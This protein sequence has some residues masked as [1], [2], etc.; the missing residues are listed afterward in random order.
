MIFGQQYTNYIKYYHYTVIVSTT[1]LLFYLYTSADFQHL[2]KIDRSNLFLRDFLPIIHDENVVKMSTQIFYVLMIQTF[3]LYTNPGFKTQHWN[4]YFKNIAQMLFLYVFK[5]S[6][7][8]MKLV[9]LH[10]MFDVSDYLFY[11][12]HYIPDPLT[13]LMYS[14]HLY[15]KEFLMAFYVFISFKEFTLL[16][17]IV[18][19]EFKHENDKIEYYVYFFTICTIMAYYVI[20]VFPTFYKVIFPKINM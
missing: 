15:M 18:D 6:Q 17:Q 12:Q 3:V 19:Q 5:Y 9:A 13:K 7:T 10:Y 20:N 8:M 16:L 1:Y 2:F 11:L 14:T 4:I